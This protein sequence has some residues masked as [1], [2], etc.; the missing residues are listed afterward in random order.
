MKKQYEDTEFDSQLKNLNTDFLWKHKQ[1]QELKNRILTDMEKLQFNESRKSLTIFKKIQKRSLTA[2]LAY[3]GIALV[4]LFGL[5]IGSAFV[6]PAMAEVVSK[7]PY[8]N[9]LFQ[10]EP[11]NRVIWRE[12]EEDGY[13]IVGVSGN[14][15]HILISIEGSEQYYQ[16]IRGEVKEIAAKVL[17]LNDYDTYTIEVKRQI[18]KVPSISEEDKYIEESLSEIYDELIK[19]QFN[20]LSQSYS[21]PSPNSRDVIIEIDVPN[22]ENRVEEIKE[23]YNKKLE[24]K[25]IE[26][27]SIQINKIDTVQK[28]KEAKWADIVHVIFSGLTAKEEFNVTDVAYAYQSESLQIIVKTSIDGSEKDST[29]KVHLIEQTINE[30]LNSRELKEKING[31]PYNIIIKGKDKQIIN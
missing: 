20:L 11:I 29:Q 14:P 27:Y 4:L 2:R 16:K 6:S 26:S 1:Q 18:D 22:T 23:I 15:S 19:L 31:E 5:L 13:K 10:S 24:A 9:K 7:V 12:L 25:N 21:H 3:S 17:K 28:E 8:L 30:F